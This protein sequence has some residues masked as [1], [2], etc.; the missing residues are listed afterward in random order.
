MRELKFSQFDDESGSLTLAIASLFLLTLLL[1]FAIIDISGVYLAKRELINL[2]EAAITRA[3]HHVDDSRYY[4]GDRTEIGLGSNGPIYLLPIDC[5]QAA[6]SL[7]SELTGLTLSNQPIAVTS[8]RCDGDQLWVKVS[9][10]VKP[11]LS[12]PLIEG[13]VMNSLLTVTA[14]LN[15]SNVIG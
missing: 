12:L 5:G 2:G 1:S 10:K 7:E 6:R 13:S 15:A 3:A 9:S 8:F 14:D 11:I 4:A